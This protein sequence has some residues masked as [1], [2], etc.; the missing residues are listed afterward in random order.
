MRASEYS[1]PGMPQIP[2]KAIDWDKVDK[3]ITYRDKN[4]A[5]VTVSREEFFGKNGK[6]KK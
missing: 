3:T 6:R 4:G 5:T 2:V 1:I